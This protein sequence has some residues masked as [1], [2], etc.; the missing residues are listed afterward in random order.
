MVSHSRCWE[1]Y[2]N[3]TCLFLPATTA[4]VLEE[5]EIPDAFSCNSL[6]LSL[7]K[8]PRNNASFHLPKTASWKL[9]VR[10]GR[11]RE[12]ERERKRKITLVVWSGCLYANK[13]VE[14]KWRREEG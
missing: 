14:K 7:V 8:W 11:Q 2:R 6:S 4:G 5:R 13:K 12:R 1:K 9:R 3:K 10:I